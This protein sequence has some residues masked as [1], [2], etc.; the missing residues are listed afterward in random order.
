ML[1]YL[2]AGES[3]GP[4]LVGIMDGFPA[5][6]PIDENYIAASLARR[7][8]A[9]GRSPRQTQEK[10]LIHITGG[11][12]RNMT[13]G[14]PVAVILENASRLSVLDPASVPRPGHAD[15]AG[16]LKYGISAAAIIRER[17]SARETAVRTALGA[18]CVRLLELLDVKI[19]G[20]VINLGG[21]ENGTYEAM[22][23]ELERARKAG[24]SIGGVFEITADNLP[25]GLG[26]HAQWDRRLS[27]KLAAQ[28]MGLNGIKGLEFGA[29]FGLAAMKGEKALDLFKKNSPLKRLSNLAGGLE[30]G[31]TN[32]MPLV[33]RAAVRPVPGQGFPVRSIDLRTGGTA[34]SEPARSD[35]TAVFA[36]AVI[37]E[38]I[39]A[40]ELADAVLE[41]FGGDSLK[42]IQSRIKAWRK[43]TAKLL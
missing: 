3:H 41:K 31:M 29:G 43:Q 35:T 22:A 17:A 38:H 40:F 1:R 26:S 27:S 16:M 33:V 10:D 18:F 19:T 15:L 28:L 2:T 11:L 14:A 32:G 24:R 8:T 20:R 37:A 36:A 5:G 12:H 13:T 25:V 39:M 4:A 9:P 42:E 23:R 7:R 21:I 6:V 34:D 30:G